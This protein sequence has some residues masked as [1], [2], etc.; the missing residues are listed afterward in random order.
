MR[1]D[2]VIFLLCENS[3]QPEHASDA[4]LRCGVCSGSGPAPYPDAGDAGDTAGVS[5]ENQ[6][7]ERIMW[8]GALLRQ[9]GKCL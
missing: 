3:R 6:R 9:V 4:A 8:I 5:M 7:I 1:R 2:Q